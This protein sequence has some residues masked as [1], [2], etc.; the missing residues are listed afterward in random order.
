MGFN[1]S[2]TV[3]IDGESHVLRF[4]APSRELYM[5]NFPFKGVF[6]GAPIIATINGRRHEIRLT[7]TPPEAKIEQD[8]S[9][10]LARYMESIPQTGSGLMKPKPPKKGNLLITF[11]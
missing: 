5:G 4:G 11:F 10:E 9:Y 3:I 1:E 8:P 2:K 7:G 6:G